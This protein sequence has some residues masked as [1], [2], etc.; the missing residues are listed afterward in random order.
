MDIKKVSQR[1]TKE[2]KIRL[3]NNMKRASSDFMQVFV[4]A[5]N[6]SAVAI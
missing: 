4:Y 1:A 2:N 5:P 6:K 3:E